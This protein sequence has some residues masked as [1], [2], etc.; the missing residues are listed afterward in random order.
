MFCGKLDKH[1]VEKRSLSPMAISNHSTVTWNFFTIST[2]DEQKAICNYCAKEISHGSQ[3]KHGFGHS[4]LKKHLTTHPMIN[5][6]YLKSAEKLSMYYAHQSV[7]TYNI[8]NLGPY[9]QSR[10]SGVLG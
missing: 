8:Q 9:S 2:T 5:R 10:V 6:K 3:D 1:N 7:Y 4:G